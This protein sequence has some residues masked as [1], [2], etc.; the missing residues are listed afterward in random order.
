MASAMTPSSCKRHDAL[1]STR[2]CH[3]AHASV[4]ISYMC[5]ISAN[6]LRALLRA[7]LHALLRTLLHAGRACRHCGQVGHRWC[8]Y[9]AHGVAPAPIPAAVP[10]AA[11]VPAC[12][13]MCAHYAHAD[14][15]RRM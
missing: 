10:A 15:S 8:T 4:D 14:R 6:L 11:A 1:D 5:I 12:L 13:G 2:E 9:A 7:M 3:D